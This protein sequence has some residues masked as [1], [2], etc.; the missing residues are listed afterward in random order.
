LVFGLALQPILS[1]LF[2][3]IIIL[4]TRYVEVGKK[5][6]ILSSQI[7]YGLVSPPPYKFLSVENT[8]LGYKD[9]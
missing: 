8:D 1:N 5:I 6:K 9:L 3:G 2:A 7:P 4:S